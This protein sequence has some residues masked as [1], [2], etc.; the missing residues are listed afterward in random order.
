MPL[1]HS[2]LALSAATLGAV[3]GQ[4]LADRADDTLVYASNSEPEN[5]SPYFNNLREGVMLSHLAWDTLIHR[6][7]ASGDYQPQLA[8]DW[9]WVDSTTLDLD[10]RRGV[11]FQNGE[12]FSADDVAFTFNHMLEPDSKIVTRQNIDW[13]DH[14]EKLDDYRV[15]FH[16][17]HPFPAALEYLAGPTPI[18]PQQYYQ[19]VGPEGYSR[20]P[21][22][23]GPYEITQVSPGEGVTL[24]KNDSYFSDSPLG[25]PS[26]G[27]L[28]FRVVPDQDSQV[29]QLMTGQVDWIWRL[30]ADQADSMASMPNITVNSGESMRVGYV[31]MNSNN[32]APEDSPFRKLKVRQAVNHALNRQGMVDN[33]VRGDSRPI[34]APCF[35][36]QAGCETGDVVQYDYDPQQARQLLEEAG[37]PDGF[38]TDLYAYRDRNYAEAI[39]NDLRAVGIRARLHFMAY[40]A[41]RERQRDGRAPM[42]FQTWGSNS[43]NDASAFTGVYFNGGADDEARDPQVMKLISQANSETDPQARNSDYRQALA[44]ISQQAYWAPLFSYSINY[45]YTDQ[46]VFTPH[47]DAIPRFYDSHWQQP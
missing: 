16:L 23:T 11:E 25:E 27:T 6:D 34:H 35:P 9:Q 45:A 29:A 39:L 26:I 36:S 24:Q 31:S 42:T 32:N 18:Y 30:P 44:R 28:V 2:L 12:P 10:L 47:T 21:I 40:S 13:I 41:V 19:Q 14:V 43:V 1:R 20:H 7:P 37:Y 33:L 15:R 22:G 5:V 3:S 38:E 17:A 46:L 4:V 8:T